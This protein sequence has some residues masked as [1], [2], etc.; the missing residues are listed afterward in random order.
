MVDWESKMFCLYFGLSRS[1][2]SHFLFIIL[3][4]LRNIE[5]ITYIITY[6]KAYIAYIF[7]FS[8]NPSIMKRNSSNA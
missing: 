1:V 8:E 2:K 3:P 4:M 5:N 7:Y 6:A